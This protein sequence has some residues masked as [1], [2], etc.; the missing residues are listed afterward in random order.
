[1]TIKRRKTTTDLREF[2]AA[3]DLV[4]RLYQE[5]KGYLRQRYECAEPGN[6]LG[7]SGIAVWHAYQ[8]G[9]LGVPA[10]NEERAKAWAK[11]ERLYVAEKKPCRRCG[12]VR[13]QSG[14]D[15]CFNC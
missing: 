2:S 4:R 10:P 13:R 14:D 3:L 5:N 12:G 6:F 8:R 9:D 1:M 11:G 15:V 7:L